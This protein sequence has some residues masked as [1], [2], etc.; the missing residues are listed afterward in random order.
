MFSSIRRTNLRPCSVL[1]LSIPW[2]LRCLCTALAKGWG[3]RVALFRCVF[4]NK[5]AAANNAAALSTPPITP[6]AIKPAFKPASLIIKGYRWR[7]K[8]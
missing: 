1:K 8:G 2:S 5:P 7:G 3:S 6:P 4:A